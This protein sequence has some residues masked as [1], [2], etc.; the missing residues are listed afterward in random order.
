[1]KS[2]FYVNSSA[3]IAVCPNMKKITLGKAFWSLEMMKEEVIF[4]EK[5]LK[6]AQKSI[7]RMM[8]YA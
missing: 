4:P 8:Q 6:K 1:M 3:D 5:T 7:Q 2:K